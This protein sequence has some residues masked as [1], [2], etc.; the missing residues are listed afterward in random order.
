M[1]HGRSP[2]LPGRF[3]RAVDSLLQ[4]VE[5]DSPSAYAMNLAHR[6]EEAYRVGTYNLNKQRNALQHEQL[7]PEFFSVGD[8]VLLFTPKVKVSS[9]IFRDKWVGPYIV[10]RKIN[11]AIMQIQ[12]LQKAND[13]KEVHVERLKKKL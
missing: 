5:V 7:L 8:H 4:D 13:I 9:D 3:S 10:T 11:K 1:V 2:H 6:M 12:N